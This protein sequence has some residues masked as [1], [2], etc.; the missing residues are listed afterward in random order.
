VSTHARA[1]PIAP[2]KNPQTDAIGFYRRVEPGYRGSS[3]VAEAALLFHQPYLRTGKP[4]YSP[5]GNFQVAIPAL[6]VC[7]LRLGLLME[8]VAITF[9]NDLYFFFRNDVDQN[10]EI[11]AM[12]LDL[13]LRRNHNLAVAALP[14]LVIESAADRGKHRQAAG[15]AASDRHRFLHRGLR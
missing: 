8:I 9:D 11:Y 14:I 5:S 3:L 4:Q 6:V 13:I 12:L 2:S 10:S 7:G 15:L 1:A